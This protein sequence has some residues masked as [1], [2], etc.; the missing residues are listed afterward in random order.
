MNELLKK[1][2]FP[3]LAISA[4]PFLFHAAYFFSGL[5]CG[6]IPRDF[7]SISCIPFASFFHVDAHHLLSNAP[8]LFFLSALFFA[9]ANSLR[10][11]IMAVALMALIG[12]L[13][14]W[15]F[16]SE[17]VHLGASLLIFGLFSAT[18]AL[19]FVSGV[20]IK[21]RIIV[22]ICAILALLLHGGMFFALLTVAPGVSWSAH[23]FG[24]LAGILSAKIT[25]NL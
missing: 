5:R 25:R 11:G 2:A 20:S 8:P 22:A 21:K 12:W 4:L 16:G 14:V 23:M 13:G 19:V 17:G 18:I 10:Q 6:V 15:F 24:F 9:A 3:V 7:D 1:I